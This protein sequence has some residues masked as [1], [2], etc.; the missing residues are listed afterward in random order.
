MSLIEEPA[1]ILAEARV[2]GQFRRLKEAEVV[3]AFQ[4]IEF[5][6]PEMMN[7]G[8]RRGGLRADRI[9]LA[10]ELLVEGGGLPPF[11][12]PLGIATDLIKEDRAFRAVL[13][14][15]LLGQ[16]CCLGWLLLLE[17]CF[18]QAEEGSFILGF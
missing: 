1:V 7:G 6:D 10:Q 5:I 13:L 14:Q 18:E 2:G 4:I 9:G 16:G 17:A 8:N 3:S 11:A 15:P 12:G